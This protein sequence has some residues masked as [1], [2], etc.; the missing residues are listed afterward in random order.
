MKRMK[1]D[2]DKKELRQLNGRS[3]P[4]PNHSKENMSMI[5]PNNWADDHIRGKYGMS[6][7]YPCGEDNALDTGIE[8]NNFVIISLCTLLTL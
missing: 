5:C 4:Y 8:C 3:M 6:S 7:H 1:Y 2:N